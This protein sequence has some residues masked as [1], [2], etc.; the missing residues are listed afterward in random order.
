MRFFLKQSIQGLLI[1]W[2]TATIL[3]FIFHALPSD[4][5]RL[6]L[7][8][9]SDLKTEMAIRKELGLDLPLWKQ[10]ILYLNDLSFLG[11]SSVDENSQLFRVKEDEIFILLKLGKLNFILKKINLKNSYQTGRPVLNT[12]LNFFPATLWLAVFSLTLAFLIGVLLGVLAAYN[13]DTWM[14]RTIIALSV[15]GMSVPSFFAALLILYVFAYVLGDITGLPMFGN[16]YEID[17]ATG[18]S[19]LSLLHIILPGITLAIRPLAIFVS[20]T[21]NAVLEQMPLDYVIY[22]RSR[23]LSERTIFWRHILKNSLNPVLTHATGWFASI[24]AGSIFVEYVFD[25]KGIGFLIVQSLEKY[26]LPLLM[27]CLLFVSFFMIL[28]NFA[29]DLVYRALDP[30]IELK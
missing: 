22:A 10:Y 6:L 3:F 13:K 4:P 29:M 8:Q 11:F 2:G 19:R 15:T 20:L 24:L 5:A 7:G 25:Y 23:G 12:I 17:L 28:I 16:L 21:R 18:E 1:L 30:R 14:D 26:D 27:G 9:R